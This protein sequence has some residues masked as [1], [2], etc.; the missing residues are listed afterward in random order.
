M[1][2]KYAI[3]IYPKGAS[4]NR[5]ASPFF[6]VSVGTKNED[7]DRLTSCIEWISD[8][9]PRCTVLIGDSLYRFTAVIQLGCSDAEA[10]EISK[11]EGARVRQKLARAV[12]AERIW[13]CTEILAKEGFMELR[14]RTMEFF[15]T[16]NSFRDSVTTDAAGFVDRQAKR[17]ALQIP[18]ADAIQLA[19]RYVLEEIAIHW[20]LAS[21]GYLLD[22]YMGHELGTLRKIL[23]NKVPSPAPALRE[24]TNVALLPARSTELVC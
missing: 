20:Y 10:L 15:E 22:F 3:K 18:R 8:R 6:C 17:E 16:D 13:T 24:R 7:F 11:R 12:G 23:E 21:H 2:M 9:Y 19:T 14:D 1:S 4:L 5:A